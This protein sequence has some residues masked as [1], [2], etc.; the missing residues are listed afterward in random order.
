MNRLAHAKLIFRW[1]FSVWKIEFFVRWKLWQ[2][3]YAAIP[4]QM[5]GFIC[6]VTIA[7]HTD[8]SLD[9]NACTRH[10]LLKICFVF[11]YSCYAI[12]LILNRCILRWANDNTL[13]HIE[14]ARKVIKKKL[15]T[16]WRNKWR[17]NYEW[18]ERWNDFFSI[19]WWR[20]NLF[21]SDRKKRHDSTTNNNSNSKSDCTLITYQKEVNMFC[22]SR[23]TYTICYMLYVYIYICN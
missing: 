6:R 5:A 14:D 19:N 9:T 22:E 11:W 1:L 2:L 12:V 23:Q 20:M 4:A 21:E 7:A 3:S 15:N 16:N 18:C 10:S 17:M 8:E 13:S